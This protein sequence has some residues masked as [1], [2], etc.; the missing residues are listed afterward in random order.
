MFPSKCDDIWG[1]ETGRLPDGV[2]HRTD[3][4]YGFPR[5]LMV[6]RILI[7]NPLDGIPKTPINCASLRE[8]ISS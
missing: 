4:Y 8:Y 2:H 6:T 3:L 5:A 7:N 1:R